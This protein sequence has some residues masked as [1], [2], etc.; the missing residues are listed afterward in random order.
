M[1]GLI[2]QWM[3][4]VYCLGEGSTHT[5]PIPFTTSNYAVAFCISENQNHRQI[6]CYNK[7]A[8]NIAFRGVSTDM[9]NVSTYADVIFIGY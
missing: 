7:T 8:S 6:Y 1:N 9:G 5:L 3:I 4:N 2:I